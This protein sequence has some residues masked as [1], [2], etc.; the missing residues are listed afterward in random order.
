MLQSVFTE[1]GGSIANAVRDVESKQSEATDAIVELDLSL[2]APEDL[3]TQ[4]TETLGTTVRC[5]GAV[6]HD[7][8]STRLFVEV[9]NAG[10]EDVAATIDDLV[11][12]D[13]VSRLST[14]GETQRYELIVAGPT[15]AQTLNEQAA[16][17]T[18]LE[19]GVDGIEVTLHLTRDVDVREFV[20]RLQRRYPDTQLVARREKQIAHRTR[21][22][23][24][25]LLEDE[26]TERQLEVLQTSYLSGFFEWPRDSTGQDVAEMLDV[27]QPTVN[28]HLRVGE[29]KLL[30]LV[31]DGL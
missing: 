21:D 12:V 17:V 28:R 19:A 3:L 4:L 14:D 11:S 25:A 30:E 23:L 9:E 18:S 16:N 8:D 15:V 24:R 31:F 29:R 27:S 26:L 13:S 10:D 20:E 1:L 7:D 6:P 2:G 22:G 5:D